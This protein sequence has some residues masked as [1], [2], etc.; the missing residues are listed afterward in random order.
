MTVLKNTDDIWT[1]VNKRRKTKDQQVVELHMSVGKNPTTN[2][3]Y[4][5][6]DLDEDAMPSSQ[7][8][9]INSLASPEQ[10]RKKRRLL[11]NT[12][13]KLPTQLPKVETTLIR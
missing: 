7:P 4:N 11:Q 12:T 5:T 6:S 8:D 1:H 13:T 3:P 2:E 10:S 9:F